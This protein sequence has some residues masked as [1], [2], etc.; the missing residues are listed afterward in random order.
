MLSV[1]EDFLFKD[2]PHVPPIIENGDASDVVRPLRLDD[3][4]LLIVIT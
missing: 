1:Q 2:V 3:V 4:A